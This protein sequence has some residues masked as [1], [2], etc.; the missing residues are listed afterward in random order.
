M[1]DETLKIKVP[2]Y[3]SD[4]FGSSF[5]GVLN[6]IHQINNQPIIKKI[7]IDFSDNHFLMPFY[8]GPLACILRNMRDNAS[9]EITIK[10]NNSYLST[11]Q[12]LNDYSINKKQWNLSEFKQKRYIPIIHFPT[13]F[14]TEVN[15]TNILEG[16]NQILKIQLG[17]PISILQAFYYFID[18]LTQNIVEH[19]NTNFGTIFCQYY[20]DKNFLYLC[21]CDMGGGILQSYQRSKKFHPKDNSEALKFALSGKSTKDI[22]E[23]MGFGVSTTKK[24]LVDGL[25]GNFLIYS[26]NSFFIQT[27]TKED[28][29]ELTED[30]FYQGCIVNLRIPTF[31]L[32]NFDYI[33][34]VE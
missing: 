24:M 1:E 26:G 16:I 25:K 19:S 31:N 18:E 7:E 22:P 8:I 2:E 30:K 27:N 21:I 13:M 28:L 33:K 3:F 5:K 9:V 11:I 10:G 12:F 23:S 6:V 32:S 20:P 29:I 15:R 4:N 34:F 17:L 14:N